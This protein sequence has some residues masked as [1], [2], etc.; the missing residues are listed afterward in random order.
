MKRE[1]LKITKSGDRELVMTRDFAAPRQLVYDAHTKPDLVRQWLGGLPGWTMPVCDMDVRVGG[2]YRWVWRN[3]TEGAEMGMGGVYRDVKAPERLV[4]TERFDEAWYPGES[5]NTLV[6][7]EQGGRTTL[8]QT[9][10]YESAAAREA[11]IKSGMEEGVTM[12]Y[13]RLDDVLAATTT[14]R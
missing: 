12:S 14:T 1:Q 5:L 4:T 7:V 13:D 3:E 10:R 2:K 9:M 11:V 6:L 8:T